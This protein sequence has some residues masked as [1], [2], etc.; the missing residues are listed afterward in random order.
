VVNKSLLG[1]RRDGSAVP[2][3]PINNFGIG[4]T[5]C[6]VL[7]RESNK[8]QRKRNVFIARLKKD[9]WDSFFSFF[10]A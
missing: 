1:D 3:C 5:I 10:S 4:E 7:G 2:I 9:E 6:R 8:Q